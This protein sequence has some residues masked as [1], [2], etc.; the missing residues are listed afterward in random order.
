MPGRAKEGMNLPCLGRI[1]AKHASCGKEQGRVKPTAP[2]KKSG[3][4]R[5]AR[6]CARQPQRGPS[7]RQGR[8]LGWHAR[9]YTRRAVDTS[10]RQQKGRQGRAPQEKGRIALRADPP[11]FMERNARAMLRTH[12]ATTRAWVLYA[13]R[14]QMP[15]CMESRFTLL[16]GRFGCSFLVVLGVY[17]FQGIANGL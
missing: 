9:S 1:A 17:F 12:R 14:E 3:G 16:H 6:G 5:R 4:L 15:P 7:G 2:S 8:G 10:Q 11:A 13:A